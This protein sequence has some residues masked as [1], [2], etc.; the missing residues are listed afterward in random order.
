MFRFANP[1]YLYLL[2]LL[3][4]VWALYFYGVWR[5]RRNMARMGRADVL[6][7]LMPDVSRYKPGAKFFLQQ[8]AL[9]V[10]VFLVARPQMGAKLEVVKRQGGGDNDCPR[11]LQFDVGPR[12]SAFPPRTVEDVVVEIVR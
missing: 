3:P 8:L 2:L 5:N 12:H 1:E 11:C 10:L 9:L 6:G 7:G 4:V